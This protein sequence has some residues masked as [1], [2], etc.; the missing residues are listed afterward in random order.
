MLFNSLQFALFF[1]LVALLHW[2]LPFRLRW[3]LLLAASYYFYMQWR[4]DYALLLVVST[5]ID[6]AASLGIARNEDP[7][8]R[9]RWLLLSIASNLGILFFFKYFNFLN[10]SFRGLF[11]QAGWAYAVPD[12]DVLLPMGISF[13]TF[14]TLSYTIDVY[15]GHIQPTR[16]FGRFAL[17]VTFFP[18]L[19]AG[20]IERAPS[21]LPQFFRERS[22]DHARTIA[23][24]KQMLWGFFKKLVIADRCAVV[25]D[26]VFNHPGQHDGASI[27][28]A[29]FL[30]A[31]QIYGDFS[32]Y[33]D[34]A[35][36]GARVLGYDLMQNFRTPYG[37][38]SISAF[39]SK[40]HISLSTWFRDYLYIPLGGNRVI[41]WRWYFNLAVVFLVS[42]LWHG[43]NW[44]FVIWGALHG[45]YL[46]LAL[47]CAPF[48]K[49]FDAAT[50]LA[51]M[52][53]LKQALNV[54][55]TFALVL[56]TWT[57]FRANRVGDLPV[58]FKAMWNMQ[59]SL[60]LTVIPVV[61]LGILSVTTLLAVLF[62]LVDGRVDRWA[63]GERP[64][65]A[66][67][68]EYGFCGALL[69]FI[70]IFGHFGGTAFIYF[71]F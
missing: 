51:R 10:D 39:W 56:L 22:Y 28:L 26:E 20:P 27:L 70:L 47:V 15:R 35:I 3:P 65:G 29:T 71:Q 41:R 8:A 40:W 38:T 53:R 13:Y 17:Y 32:G 61:Q 69:A 46:I 7:A 11:A 36:G 14:Q 18:Q 63:K 6:Y 45:L 54:A 1:P 58:L 24:L 33:S 48:W 62:F 37:A 43:A 2:L 59:P 64:W 5:V 25:V 4:I 49:R 31:L 42:G 67:W 68:K 19:V 57:V 30:F 52:P 12:L 60:A 16:H 9:K 21:L 23:G 44:T 55:V 50:G 66:R 34:I